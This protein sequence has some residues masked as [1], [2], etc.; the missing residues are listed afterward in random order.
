MATDPTA[1]YRRQQGLAPITQSYDPVVVEWT[2]RAAAETGADPVALLAT[3][4]QESGARRYPQP[5]D[6]G[7]SFGPFQFHRGGALGSHPKEWASTYAAAL[8]RAKEFARLKV[9]GGVGAAAVQRPADRSLY[10]QGV[11]THLEQAR[12]ILARSGPIPAAAAP[13]K[14]KQVTAGPAP[15]DAPSAAAR[16][17]LLQGLLADSPVEDLLGLMQQAQGQGAPASAAPLAVSPP[18]SG[19]PKPTPLKSK[20]ITPATPNVAPSASDKRVANF[21][22]TPVQAWM[23]PALAYARQHGWKGRLTSGVRTTELQKTLYA[24]YQAGGNIAAKPGQSNHE[25]QNG[26]AFD[27]TDPQ[28]LWDV[29]QGF[30]GRRPIWA[31]TVGLRDSVHFSA[32]G[33]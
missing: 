20:P 29:L 19:A 12:A 6:G 21:E 18:G 1:A 13:A 25:I 30:K 4:I 11:Q 32:T 27:A 23:L 26:G 22:G 31:P 15:T 3:A 2:R 28:Q 24:R 5:G 7:T 16:A 10:A 9:H 33:R 8:N 17:A 14:V